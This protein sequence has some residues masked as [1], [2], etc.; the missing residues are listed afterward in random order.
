[1]IY[2]C[3]LWQD[4]FQSIA[5]ITMKNREEYCKING[6]KFFHKTYPNGDPNKVYTRLGFRKVELILKALE[7]P[8]CEWVWF[9]DCDGLITNFRIQL[10]EIM[11]PYNYDS[12]VVSCDSQGPNAGSMFVGKSNWTIDFLNRTLEMKNLKENE[13]EAFLELGKDNLGEQMFILPQKRM[14]AYQYDLYSIEKNFNIPPPSGKIN[15]DILGMDGTWER[16]DFFIH[17]AG[18]F[19]LE[20]KLE[21][22]KIYEKKVIR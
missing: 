7:Q 20:K 3:S 15:V 19:S 9:A 14:N 17:W 12:L 8:D 11:N 5:D 22:S 1:M 18:N 13:M 6:Y 10:E 2:C 21:L 4:N 16:G